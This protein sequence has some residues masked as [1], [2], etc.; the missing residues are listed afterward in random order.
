MLNEDR[1]LTLRVSRPA[2]LD[3]NSRRCGVTGSLCLRAV[4][5]RMVRKECPVQLKGDGG[6]PV[7]FGGRWFL[8]PG[9][10]GQRGLGEHA[11]LVQV[12]TTRLLAK[13]RLL[14]QIVRT[15]ECRA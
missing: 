8:V 11:D 13:G 10:Q 3:G 5:C 12:T 2:R 4:H 9:T 7:L 6:C 15:L 14:C 1:A